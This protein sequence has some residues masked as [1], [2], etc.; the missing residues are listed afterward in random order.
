M[1]AP[2]AAGASA[3]AGIPLHVRSSSE[4]ST[5][6]VNRVL[7]A[8]GG[9]RTGLPDSLS[10][11]QFG[12]RPEDLDRYD[13]D[14]NERLDLEE[15]RYWVTHAPPHVELRVRIGATDSDL[16]PVEVHTAP[17]LE[18]LSVRV[19]PSGLVSLVDGAVQL[20]FGVSDAERTADLLKKAF[21]QSFK[22]VRL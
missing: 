9:S 15:L 19:T 20:E 12:H 1:A 2:Q 14:G 4:S 7:S 21:V 17:T 10:I 5:A 11:Q 22:D 18:G 13:V 8:Y 16:P 3:T 6:L